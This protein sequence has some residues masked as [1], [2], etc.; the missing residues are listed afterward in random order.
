MFMIRVSHEKQRSSTTRNRNNAIRFGM[1]TLADRVKWVIE[2]VAKT[3]PAHFAKAI[4]VGRASV[5]KWLGGGTKK[6]DA[7][8]VFAIE[9]RYGVSARWITT[10]KGPRFVK[11]PPD[12][13]GGAISRAIETMEKLSPEA[14]DAVAKMLD[15]II[16]HRGPNEVRDRKKIVGEN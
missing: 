3:I 5:S 8:H 16:Q 7:D 14:Q 10:G 11:T 9:N 6:I 12:D 15:E 13:D 4:G 2:D 1:E